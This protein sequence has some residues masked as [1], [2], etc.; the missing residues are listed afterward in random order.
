MSLCSLMDTLEYDQTTITD[1]SFTVGN[2]SS[3]TPFVDGFDS[4]MVDQ[5]MI[6]E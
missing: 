5:W 2:P 1:H 4:L 3:I 6:Q